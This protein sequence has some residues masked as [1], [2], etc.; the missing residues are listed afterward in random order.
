MK[1][2]TWTSNNRD[3]LLARVTVLTAGTALTSAVGA[4]GLG[5]GLAAAS[6]HATSA[7]AGSSHTN[8]PS[9][10]TAPKPTPSQTQALEAAQVQVQV[11]NGTGIPGTAH[12]AARDLSAAGFQVV[13]IGNA[14]TG[15]VDATTITYPAGMADAMRLLADSTGV[16][17]S[18]P[19]GAG[20][21]LVL[22]VGP[23]WQGSKPP[24][25]VPQ[26]PQQNGGG[27][28]NGGGGNGGGGGG[29][30]SGGS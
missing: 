11:L 22:T 19:A 28:G 5:L 8:Q 15:R 6:T 1:P 25:Y 24:V 4:V 2:R 29:S 3:A 14:P 20:S 17:A 7:K 9:S 16:T 10:P 18:A 30:T 21:V 27:G 13:G 23:D 12:A 26:Q